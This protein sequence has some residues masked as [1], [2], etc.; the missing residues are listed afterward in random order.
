MNM[1]SH[2]CPQVMCALKRS[3]TS[4]IRAFGD[5]VLV[6]RSAGLLLDSLSIHWSL[7]VF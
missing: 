7:L 3:L 4:F 2:M 1:N 6:M 5:S